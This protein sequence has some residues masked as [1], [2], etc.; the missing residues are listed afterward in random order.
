M[1]RN[2]M[3]EGLDINDE[4]YFLMKSSSDLI[5]TKGP[6]SHFPIH[7]AVMSGCIDTVKAL[8][9]GAD[10]DINLE[11]STN[12]GKSPLSIACTQGYYEITEFLLKKGVSV[13]ETKKQKKNSLIWA[14]QNGQIHIVSLLLRHGI[15]PDVPDSSG[16]TAAH[17]AA[18]YGWS[19]IL[20]F[21]IENGAHPDLKN[22]WNS[23]PAMIAM[24]KNHFGCLDYLM[25]LDNVDKSMVDNEGRSVISQ[26]CM[27][28]T[29]DTLT[30]IEYM[31]KFKHLDYSM[32]DA[33][34]WTCMHFLVANEAPQYKLQQ[35]VQGINM[36]RHA[37][38]E[39]KLGIKKDEQNDNLPFQHAIAKRPA[40][41]KTARKMPAMARTAFNSGGF[42]LQLGLP[43]DDMDADVDE[44]TELRNIKT[45]YDQNDIK[46]RQLFKEARERYEDSI[47]ECAKHI[48]KHGLKEDSL[49]Y[50]GYS[51][52]RLAIDN[53]N[54][55]VALWLINNL[56]GGDIPKSVFSYEEETPINNRW[57]SPNQ[58][59]LF[60]LSVF[61]LEIDYEPILELLL[62]RG[63]KEQLKTLMNQSSMEMTPLISFVKSRPN[64]NGFGSNDQLVEYETKQFLRYLDLLLEIANE[65]GHDVAT[66]MKFNLSSAYNIPNPTREKVDKVFENINEEKLDNKV[67]SFGL[68]DTT[69]TENDPLYFD[70]SS[71]LNSY[72]CQE[73]MFNLLH[74]LVR[75]SV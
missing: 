33:N 52:V 36:K 55:K 34:G 13:H 67:N 25:E 39:K 28:Y 49:T 45:Y 16:N 62:K 69:L 47:L 74:V 23:T 12:D 31:D 44:Q 48:Y 30:Q 73:V 15:H 71:E 35:E 4:D 40:M 22:D 41:K 37:E 46:H 32:K 42:E 9:D 60:K 14:T 8:I 17:Y 57:N 43:E 26:L 54:V 1:N 2:K 21:L 6:L 63:S 58:S 7:F 10:G 27:S 68:I 20:K 38:L 18:G 29:K 61:Y 5:G 56:C 59:F 72:H 19:H 51:T 50:D 64:V 24:L 75:D 66:Q 65:C 3:L 53:G 11:V 70:T